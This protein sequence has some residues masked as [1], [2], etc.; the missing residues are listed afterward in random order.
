MMLILG[1]NPFFNVNHRAGVSRSDHDASDQEH[2]LGVAM[3]VLD[4]ATSS[5]VSTFMISDYEIASAITHKFGELYPDRSLDLALVVP[6]PHSL[7][8]MIS[9]HGY[10]RTATSLFGFDIL[11]FGLRALIAPLLGLRGLFA[12]I[13][14]SYLQSRIREYERAN[15]RVR[16]LCLHNV[17]VDLLVANRRADALLAFIDS[18]NAMGREAVL[19]TQNIP[20]LTTLIGDRECVIC[21][22]YNTL[23]F[24][25]NPSRA[26]VLATVGKKTQKLKFWAM[27]ILASGAVPPTAALGDE[28][29]ANFDAILYATTKPDRLTEFVEI[30]KLH[31][32]HH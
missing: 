25:T 31:D 3:P 17:V 7:N 10:L 11:R 20:A 13:A 9:E 12:Q 29:L 8:K 32:S 27:Q 22:S 15:V 5:S 21:G 30:M 1:D 2:T 24:M 14:T 28:G 19:L 26:D 16:M 4:R 18:V 6:Y 23:G